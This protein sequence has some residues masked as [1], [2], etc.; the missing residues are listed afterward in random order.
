MGFAAVQQIT[1]D[2]EIC[3]KC[4]VLF[5]MPA[6]M[7]AAVKRDKAQFFC[8]SGHGQSYIENEADRLRKKLDEQIRETTRQAERALAAERAEQAAVS[9]R[10]KVERTLKRAQAGVCTCCQRTF[11]NLQRHMQTKHPDVA[12]ST[13]P[14]AIDVKVN[15][16]T[17]A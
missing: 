13:P 5:A 17:K 11:P 14:A 6:A 2:T 16:R 15:A 4:G 7:L 8:P 1:L 3:Y 9:A 10:K 12:P